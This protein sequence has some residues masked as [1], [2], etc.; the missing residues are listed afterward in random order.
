MFEKVYVMK[1]IKLKCGF[2][3]YLNL[4]FWFGIYCLKVLGDL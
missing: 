3:S 4:Y 2:I 1:E